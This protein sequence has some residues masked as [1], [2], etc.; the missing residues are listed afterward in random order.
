MDGRYR[1]L[2]KLGSG[3][4]GV[5]YEGKYRDLIK[6]INTDTS[7]NS[8]KAIDL[9]TNQKVGIKLEHFTILDSLLGWEIEAYQ[10]L[11]GRPGVA[12]VYANGEDGEYLYLVLELL[13]P[14]LK[15]LLS[16]CGGKFSMKT[17]LMLA[18]QLIRRLEHLHL[19]D[20]VHRDV[21]PH[22]FLM[23]LGRYGNV[24]YMIDFGMCAYSQ[25]PPSNLHSRKTTTIGTH[26][27]ASVSG[28]L[29]F[30]EF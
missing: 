3:S 27:F 15:D 6:S 22:N 21:G 10:A 2:R 20:L 16:Y 13:G 30:G 9:E 25:P 29:L 8:V 7:A 24:V 23:G 5:V 18:D 1:L 17:V 12:R 19:K 11:S 14:S 26:S 28:H 4:F